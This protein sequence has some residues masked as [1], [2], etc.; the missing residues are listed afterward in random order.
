MKLKIIQNKSKSDSNRL[1]VRGVNQE[2]S[3]IYKCSA[4]NEFSW[5]EHAETINVEGKY[6]KK[7]NTKHIFN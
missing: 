4:R 1:V 3:G 6:K 7:I 2:D 5:S